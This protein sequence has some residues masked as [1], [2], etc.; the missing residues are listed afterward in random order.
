MDPQE[1]RAVGQ[2]LAFNTAGSFTTN[3]TGR[4]IGRVHHDYFTQMAGL[5][6]QF[7]S[8]ASHRFSHCLHPWNRPPR[9]GT[10]AT[11]GLDM[12]RAALWFGFRLRPVF[13]RADF[14]GVPQN[15]PAYDTVKL[16]ERRPSN[17][18]VRRQTSHKMIRSRASRR[19]RSLAGSIKCWNNV[20]AFST[21]TA[22]TLLRIQPVFELLQCF[23]SLHPA[24]LLHLER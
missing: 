5:R 12:T 9:K 11:S 6:T 19:G 10:L 14:A 8:A 24:G 15:L 20:A 4:T 16:V 17:R 7:T 23:R 18:P 2:D 21:P 22:P 3:T 13:L 1:T